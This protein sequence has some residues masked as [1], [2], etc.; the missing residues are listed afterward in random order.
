MKAKTSLIISTYNWT[1]ALDLCLLSI[2]KKSVLPDEVIIADDGST[3]ETYELIKKHQLTFKV[4]LNHVWHKDEGF[5]LA[6]IRNRAIAMAQNKYIIQIDGD[7]ILHK[8]FVKDHLEL[9]KKGTFITGSRVLMDKDLSQHLMKTKNVSVLIYNSGITNHINF[10][11]IKYLREYLADRYK[12]QDIRYI[13]GC[14]MAFW[15][16]DLIRVNGYNEEF[17][18]WGSEDNEIAVRLMNAG[19]KKRAI[20]FGGIVFHI[21]HPEQCRSKSNIN[22]HHLI[23]AIKNKITYCSHGLSQ[24]LKQ[25]FSYSLSINEA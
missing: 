9:A 2:S 23:N 5:Q 1:E 6:K 19:L 14:N 12:Q 25:K 10:L 22:E 13:R 17:K 15:K 7:L 18:G 11:R 3:R 20:K 21:D 8:H 4:P 16:E 24:Y